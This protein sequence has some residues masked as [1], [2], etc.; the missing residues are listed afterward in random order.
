VPPTRQARVEGRVRSSGPHDGLRGHR[1]RQPATPNQSTA[2][3]VTGLDSAVVVPPTAARNRQNVVWSRDSER[4]GVRRRRDGD[5]GC[6]WVLPEVAWGR[7][8]PA[9][10]GRRPDRHP[11][12][13]VLSMTRASRGVAHVRTHQCAGRRRAESGGSTVE[14]RIRLDDRTSHRLVVASA[15]GPA[16]ANWESRGDRNRVGSSQ[17]P[18]RARTD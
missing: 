18:A 7:D 10:A 12:A 16:R 11:E 5:G 14:R 17:F 9:A 3:N 2:L 15:L 13:D 8:R 4:G 6:G 1:P